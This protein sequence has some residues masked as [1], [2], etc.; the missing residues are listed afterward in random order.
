MTGAAL[1]KNSGVS[2]LVYRMKIE[3]GSEKW[4]ERIIKWMNNKMTMQWGL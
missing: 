4:V 2:V 1:D 3:M